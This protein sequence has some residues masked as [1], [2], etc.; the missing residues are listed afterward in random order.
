MVLYLVDGLKNDVESV[1]I[2]KLIL[3]EVNGD[4]YFARCYNLTIINRNFRMK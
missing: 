2:W 3:F 4:T 1:D